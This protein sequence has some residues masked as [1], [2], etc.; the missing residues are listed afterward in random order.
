MVWTGA[1]GVEPSLP[2]VGSQSALELYVPR[3]AIH[4]TLRPR[5]VTF[6]RLFGAGRTILCVA[7]SP[8]PEIP[9]T[10]RR[11]AIAAIGEKRGEMSHEVLLLTHQPLSYEVIENHLTVK[12][13]M[14][15]ENSIHALFHSGIFGIR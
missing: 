5:W 13:A 14:F 8:K 10:V 2:R 15:R 1:E 9:A 3:C 12:L 4:V 7:F 6:G 11:I